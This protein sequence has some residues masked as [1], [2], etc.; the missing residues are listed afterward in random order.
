[1]EL[2][3]K[4]ESAATWLNGANGILITAGAGMGVDSGLPDFRGAAG[5]WRAYPALQAGGT[6]FQDIASGSL[7]LSRPEFAWGFYAHRL[8]LY[9]RIQPHA[10]FD[11]VRRWGDGTLKRG[12]Q[13][14]RTVLPP[15]A[16]VRLS[17]T[18][19]RS[20]AW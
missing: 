3:E 6:S 11:I 5:F 17:A 10:G 12:M 13:P 20:S 1:M 14:R 18:A 19:R 16:S 7:F 4:L 9:R 2:H 15:Q 8:S